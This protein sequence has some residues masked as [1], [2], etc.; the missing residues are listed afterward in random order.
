MTTRNEP[1]PG[2]AELLIVCTGNVCRSPYLE[3][4]LRHELAGVCSDV[5][6]GP[7][8]IA[9]AGTR[10]LAGCDMD[11]STREL[12]AVRQ[13]VGEPFRARQLE[14]SMV[15]DAALVVTMARSHRTAVARLEPRGMR[16]T[17]ALLDLV[18]LMPYV[19]SS[20]PADP[21]RAATLGQ[22]LHA[23][24][25]ELANVRGRVPPLAPERSEIL[26]PIGRDRTA[27]AAMAAQLEA[28]IPQLM[29]RLTPD[30][31]AEA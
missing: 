3:R 21:G 12:L 28:A 26:D 2:A 20:A 11:P 5:A 8:C 15:R 17:Y 13:G 10:A 6:A 23:L 24:T 19:S 1:R 14:P 29:A 7:E 4:R 16:K 27:F 31:V 25:A 22:R 18:Q 30:A 9:S